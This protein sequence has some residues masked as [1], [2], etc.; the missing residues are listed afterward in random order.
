MV[1]VGVDVP[2]LGLMAVQGQP[3]T[4]A[5]Y[6]Q[7]TSRIGR[8]KAGPGLVVV[9]FNAAKARDRSAFEAFTA[10]H[11]SI[12]RDVEATSVTPFASRARDKALSATLVSM[13]RHGFPVMWDSPDLAKLTDADLR[14]VVDAIEARVRAI[15][16]LEL[17][18]TEMQINELLDSWLDSGPRFYLEH[19]DLA[20]SL[21]QDAETFARSVAKGRNPD[22]AWPVMNNMRSVEAST[23]FRMVEGLKQEPSQNRPVRPWRA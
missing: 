8:S 3:K 18:Q 16:P 10:W 11:G 4:R 6:I 13:F 15:E 20:N 7:A 12:Y 1:S 9:S 17:A 23:P 14:T 21:L 19:S 2:R 5:E 22:E